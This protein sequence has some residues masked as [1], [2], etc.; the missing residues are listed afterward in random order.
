M[1]PMLAA[2]TV[3]VLAS[4]TAAEAPSWVFAVPTLVTKVAE[5]VLE[6][7]CNKAKCE[8]GHPREPPIQSRSGLELI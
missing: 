8:E 5:N 1:P 2:E 3:M 7:A 6:A 4:G